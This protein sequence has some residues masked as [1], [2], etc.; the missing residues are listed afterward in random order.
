MPPSGP[1]VLNFNQGSSS[2]IN[3]SNNRLYYRT[4]SPRVDTFVT[5]NSADLSDAGVANALSAALMAVFPFVN[6]GAQGTQLKLQLP[7]IT[8]TAS[9]NKLY[10]LE[11]TPGTYGRFVAVI[12]PGIYR[13]AGLAR[14]IQTAVTRPATDQPR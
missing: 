3:S 2:R 1:P 5:L 8:I 9:S 11:G 12:P 4:N 14:R 10:W 13:F 6:V 7:S